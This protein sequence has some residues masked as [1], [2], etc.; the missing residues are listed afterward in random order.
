MIKVSIMQSVIPSGI[1]TVQTIGRIEDMKKT[2]ILQA[3]IEDITRKRF[4]VKPNYDLT[5]QL[6]DS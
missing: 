1:Q 3:E 2:S 4:E 5:P 6:P